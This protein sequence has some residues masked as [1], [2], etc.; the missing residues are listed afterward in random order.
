MKGYLVQ[1]LGFAVLLTAIPLLMNSNNVLWAKIAG[2]IVVVGISIALRYWLYKTGKIKPR[3]AEVKLNANDKF[4]LDAHS[5]LFR[6]LEGK[7]KKEFLRILTRVLAELDFDCER[8]GQ[9]SRD[10][11]LA[12]ATLL[13][14]L[15]YK[16]EVKSQKNKIVVFTI[17]S[18]LKMFMQGNN[19]VIM[20]DFK[21]IETEL[22]KIGNFNDVSNLP[23]NLK[24]T[25]KSFIDLV[26]I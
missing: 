26:N 21:R 14:I 23:E 10:E 15:L 22:E 19:P 1:L 16:E 18:E 20:V 5:P 7:K 13:S 11:G 2:V 6:S 4:Y 24:N 25:L 9:V 8:E 17:S 12:F 3:V